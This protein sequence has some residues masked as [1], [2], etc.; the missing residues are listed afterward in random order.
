MKKIFKLTLV[1]IY[2]PLLVIAFIMAVI[3]SIFELTVVFTYN[4]SKEWKKKMLID[5]S[6]WTDKLK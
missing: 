2:L 6:D 1:L 4:Q 3:T 5:A